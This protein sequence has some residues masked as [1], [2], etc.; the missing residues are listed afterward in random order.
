MPT[1]VRTV[2]FVLILLFTS[3]SAYGAKLD[4]WYQVEVI[5][6]ANTTT[7][8]TGEVWPLTNKQYPPAMIYVGPDSDDQI[9]PSTLGQMEDLKV[10]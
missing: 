10:T 6:F 8:D 5:V 3:F 2:W 7:T 9:R 1:Q 4:G